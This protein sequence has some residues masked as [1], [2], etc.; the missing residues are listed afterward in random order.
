MFWAEGEMTSSFMLLPNSLI[1]ITRHTQQMAS[2]QRSHK[3]TASLFIQ[4][5]NWFSSSRSANRRVH[6]SFMSF[7]VGHWAA[8]MMA[9]AQLASAAS[10][11]RSAMSSSKL[12]AAIA[13]SC[14][15]AARRAE[16]TGRPPCSAHT[17][18]SCSITSIAVW[19]SDASRCSHPS[20][21]TS[22]SHA[23]SVTTPLRSLCTRCGS[24]RPSSEFTSATSCGSQSRSTGDPGPV[25]APRMVTTPHLIPA[26]TSG[27]TTARPGPRAVATPWPRRV[28]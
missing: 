24:T 13:I 4:H 15:T 6:V 23:T 20:S 19:C 8:G 21:S 5:T 3:R 26:V 17:R 10:V 25:G 1:S 16:S 27:C 7:L 2:Y 11:V 12:P 28:R 18:L 9:G 22:S 14:S